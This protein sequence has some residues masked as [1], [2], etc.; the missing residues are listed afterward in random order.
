MRALSTTRY[1]GVF[2]V[3]VTLAVLFVSTPARP[4]QSQ[5]TPLK[6]VIK[7]LAPFVMFEGERNV[8]FSIELWDEI[9]KRTGRTF[10]YERVD[11]V[12]RQLE[13][14]KNQ[15]ADLAI[16]GISITRERE[17]TVD[18]SLPYFDAGLQILVPAS[19]GTTSVWT[20]ASTF[21]RPTC[22]RLSLLCLRLS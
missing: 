2:V 13:A 15:T 19:S 14:V 1:T 21:F 22:C 3:L 12:A 18:F 9:A 20:L 4:A 17:T 16:T 7:P 6:V 10:V 5:A 11:T 8:G